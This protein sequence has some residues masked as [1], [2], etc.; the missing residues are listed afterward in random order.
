MNNMYRNARGAEFNT[1]SAQ[2]IEWRRGNEHEIWLQ[3]RLVE[4][5]DRLDVRE[6][7]CD[8][9]GLNDAA[10]RLEARAVELSIELAELSEPSR[11]DVRLELLATH[12]VE[13]AA[14][15][16]ELAVGQR[17][18]RSRSDGNGHLEARRVHREQFVA[19]HLAADVFRA[20]Q[21]DRTLAVRLW[22]V[23]PD[24]VVREHFL[25]RH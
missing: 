17:F 8:A 4:H 20:D 19:Q 23:A 11:R 2:L 24:L 3:V 25:V 12:E 15:L 9:A 1:K 10:H 6:E 16:F 5:A 22:E 14:V 18:G 21:D 7:Q 13:V